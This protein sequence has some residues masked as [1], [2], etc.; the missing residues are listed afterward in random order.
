MEN[1][2]HDSDKR[3]T[4]A[5]VLDYYA[6]V[7][8][9]GEGSSSSS[10][11][12]NYSASFDREAYGDGYGDGY[13]AGNRHASV[14]ER[15]D[16]NSYTHLN[17]YAAK[18]DDG[19]VKVGS[20]DYRDI[21]RPIDSAAS[22]HAETDAAH[23]PAHELVSPLSSRL[24]LT[25]HSHSSHYTS[26]G[27]IPSD[28]LLKRRGSALSQMSTA[29]LNDTQS[30]HS[31]KSFTSDS[32]IDLPSPTDNTDPM[33][34]TRDM[35][36][37]NAFSSAATFSGAN[38]SADR[39]MRTAEAMNALAKAA[40]GLQVWLR[41]VGGENRPRGFSPPPLLNHSQRYK[42]EQTLS[43]ALSLSLN[44]MPTSAS[45]P[46]VHSTNAQVSSSPYMNTPVVPFL[47]DRQ[48][49]TASFATNSTF[50]MR[51]GSDVNVAHDLTT[52]TAALGLN[53]SPPDKIPEHLPYPGAAMLKKT[54]STNSGVS[55]PKSSGKASRAA[56]FFANL[57]RRTS[58]KSPPKKLHI[59]HPSPISKD[60]DLPSSISSISPPLYTT[61]PGTTPPISPNRSEDYANEPPTAPA[62]TTSFSGKDNKEVTVPARHS[63]H[64]KGSRHASTSHINLDGLD[65]T[66]SGPRAKPGKSRNSSIF[67]L[68]HVLN[69]EPFPGLANLK[70]PS[71]YDLRASTPAPL[72]QSSKKE[73]G[74]DLSPAFKASLSRL[75]NLLPQAAK[76]DLKSHLKKANGDEMRA[77]GTYIESQR[78]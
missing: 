27:D 39:I 50:P 31:P 29:A 75:E 3:H 77:V 20:Y 34:I 30:Q 46:S 57:G 47:H 33:S 72:R 18:G 61:T 60:L 59:G 53:D 55:T 1:T 14:L 13:S 4:N 78:T 74:E 22:A 56:G 41:C 49:S 37:P 69:P 48:H 24:P 5:S 44:Q 65:R 40:S 11:S 63:S 6:Y 51:P 76:S 45:A 67:N 10:P 21:S 8:E 23:A 25:D 71:K 52:K 64:K 32:T 9:T 2:P 12:S 43:P 36:L 42:R 66:P 70:P 7:A 62:S 17:V 19:P 28:V 54:G 58:A 35:P 26:I 38:S 73:A 16:S 15:M 68:S